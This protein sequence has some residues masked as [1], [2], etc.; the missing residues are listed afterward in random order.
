VGRAD[1]QRY[2]TVGVRKPHANLF[3]AEADADNHAQGL[4]VKRNSVR[5]LRAGGP[6]ADPLVAVP[7]GV[8]APAV[9]SKPKFVG[10]L[11]PI[12]GES[13]RMKGEYGNGERHRRNDD[14]SFP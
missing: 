12:I 6:G 3:A 5:C 8:V 7:M 1:N 14:D 10:A 9:A 4:V 11:M 2:G 13:D